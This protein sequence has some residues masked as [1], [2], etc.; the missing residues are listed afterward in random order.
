MWRWIIT[1]STLRAGTVSELMKHAKYYLQL[2]LFQ[3]DWVWSDGAMRI[4][5]QSEKIYVKAGYYKNWNNGNVLN[6]CVLTVVGNIRV[7][8]IYTTPNLL[9]LPKRWWR[10]WSIRI[11]TIWQHYYRR[12]DRPPLHIMWVN[13]GIKTKQ[14]FDKWC[15]Q[16]FPS[17]N[18][19]V[20]VFN[21]PSLITPSAKQ[22]LSSSSKS[23]C[24]EQNVYIGTLM[25]GINSTLQLNVKTYNLWACKR[26]SISV[27]TNR[28]AWEI[29]VLHVWWH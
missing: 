21:Q 24:K 29:S 4:T 1:S 5:F 3:K 20:L 17:T 14:D 6:R 26:Y 12:A 23:P 25:A 16:T 11:T 22:P 15:K 13:I 19:F 27:D 8:G 2:P 10:K 28:D 7:I 9:H 18:H